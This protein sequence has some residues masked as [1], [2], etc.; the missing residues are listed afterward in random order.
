MNIGT[1]PAEARGGEASQA[2]GG[3]GARAKQ[4]PP[5]EPRRRRQD[6]QLG[7][8]TAPRHRPLIIIS[9]LDRSYHTINT[10]LERHPEV[11][12]ALSPRDAA[13]GP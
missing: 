13:R 1:E 12:Q 6:G 4:A 10:L 7:V 8:R 3:S 11:S 5:T 2:P 9:T